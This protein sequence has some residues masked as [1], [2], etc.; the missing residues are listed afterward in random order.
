MSI[1]FSRQLV[2]MP[3]SGQ[4]EVEFDRS[5][6]LPPVHVCVCGPA[7]QV[8]FILSLP[9]MPPVFYARRAVQPKLSSEH[10]LMLAWGW[11]SPVA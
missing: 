9:P 4:S 1:V 2:F 7:E 10:A 3:G 6:G 8:A 5:A 11:R